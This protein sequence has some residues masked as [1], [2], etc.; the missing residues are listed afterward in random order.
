MMK[1]DQQLFSRGFMK[2]FQLVF[3]AFTFSNALLASAER[4]VKITSF[5]YTGSR[6]STAELCGSIA[7]ESTGIDIIE[8][9][10][11]PGYKKPG[12]Y[13]VIADKKG[14]FCVV[15][16]T[17]TGKADVRA[18]DAFTVLGVEAK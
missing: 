2:Y 6:N 10:S 9:I 7:G 1:I 12:V 11:D 4:E 8:V 14:Q 17:L 3:V 13:S 15:V 16:N 18:R 5:N